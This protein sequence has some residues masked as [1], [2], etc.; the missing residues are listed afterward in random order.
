MVEC[1]TIRFTV[2]IISQ[3][4]L[5]PDGDGNMMQDNWWTY[6]ANT[7]FEFRPADDLSI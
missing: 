7:T 4:D 2:S 6:A 5:D 3:N 1:D